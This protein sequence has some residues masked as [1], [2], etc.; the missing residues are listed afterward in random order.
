MF[1]RT[2]RDTQVGTR[3]NVEL[4]IPEL[5]RTVRVEAETVYRIESRSP[6]VGLRFL[7]FPE[8]EEALLI[9]TLRELE[10]RPQ[11]V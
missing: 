6:G 2:G 5:G 11:A 1:V 9:E 10:G 7:D 3:E 4:S 8:N